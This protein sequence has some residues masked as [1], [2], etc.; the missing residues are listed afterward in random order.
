[1]SITRRQDGT[2]LG[3]SICKNLIEINGE[4]INVESQLGKGSKFWFTWNIELLSSMTTISK[5]RQ[6]NEQLIYILPHAIRQKRILIIHPVE[7]MRNVILNYLKK[8]EK[9]DAFDTF[10]KAIRAAKAYKES[11]DKPAYD[12]AFIGLNE[13]NEEAVKAALELRGLEMNSN[14]L[15]IIFIVF[16]GNEGNKLAKKLIGKV[17]R[18]IFLFILQLHGKN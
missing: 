7:M 15:E 5:F 13:N 17:G 3:H 9:V 6:F 16:P 4:I 1:M 12:I 10:D 11:H 2:G 18:S 14:K 8:V